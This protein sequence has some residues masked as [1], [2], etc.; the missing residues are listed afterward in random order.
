[1]MRP[2]GMRDRYGVHE[3]ADAMGVCSD[4]LLRLLRARGVVMT[5]RRPTQRRSPSVSWNALVAAFPDFAEG[6]AKARSRAATL[7][8]GWAEDYD[9]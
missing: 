7:A 2:L 8:V 4:T 3:L 5:P 9:C 6:A 1:V